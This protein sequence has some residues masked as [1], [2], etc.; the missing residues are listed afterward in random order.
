[1]VQR[2][3][4]ESIPLERDRVGDTVVDVIRY[5][6][7]WSLIWALMDPVSCVSCVSWMYWMNAAETHETFH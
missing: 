2:V 7:S 6:P 5:A 3:D 1:M 4:F